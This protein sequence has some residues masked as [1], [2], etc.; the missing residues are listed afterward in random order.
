MQFFEKN[1]LLT[2]GNISKIL[3]M[4]NLNTIDYLGI[5]LLSMPIYK[6]TV[7]RRVGINSDAIMI[8]NRTIDL[9]N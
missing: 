2:Q 8:L 9:Y 1:S 6:S 7:D 3:D 4:I 5:K